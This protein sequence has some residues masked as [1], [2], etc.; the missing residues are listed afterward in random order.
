MRLLARAAA[1]AGLP[2]AV[3]RG[4]NPRPKISLALPRPVGVATTCDLMVVE[5]DEPVA[6]GELAS[7]L[8]RRLPPGVEVNRREPLPPGRPPRVAAAAYELAL[9]EAAAA[10]VRAALASLE[11]R[12]RWEVTR[13]ARRSGRRDGT[14]RTLDI[15]PA[16]RGPELD[17]RT[18]RFTIVQTDAGAA[19]CEEV[20]ALAGL[21]GPGGGLRRDDALAQLVRTE[22]ECDLRPGRKD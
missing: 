22:L 4:F 12:P 1:R 13:R 11:G 19:R 3:T 10:G 20:L 17:G 7:G 16:V 6:G 21:D 2:V 5:L 18:L 15:R 9:P 14:P 8:N